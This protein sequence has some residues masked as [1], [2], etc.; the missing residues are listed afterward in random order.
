MKLKY[1]ALFF[2]AGFINAAEPC[3]YDEENNCNL[4]EIK[5]VHS[6]DHE[7]DQCNN[8][9]FYRNLAKDAASTLSNGLHYAG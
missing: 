9:R 2:F 5:I 4:R 7:C 8:H 6:V 1:V 3:N